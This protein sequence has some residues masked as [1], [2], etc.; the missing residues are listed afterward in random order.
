[1]FKAFFKAPK[2]IAKDTITLIDEKQKTNIQL[3]SL[4]GNIAK[5]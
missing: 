3:N 2:W 1:M 5:T 4:N